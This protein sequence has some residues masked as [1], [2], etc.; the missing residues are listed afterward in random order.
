MC[1][2]A[3]NNDKR[4]IQIANNIVVDNRLSVGLLGKFIQDVKGKLK[5]H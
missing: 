2:K 3:F 1:H 4:G 5:T